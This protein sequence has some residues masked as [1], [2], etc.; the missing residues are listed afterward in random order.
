MEPGV[1]ALEHGKK[2]IQDWHQI[3]KQLINQGITEPEKI[4]E[5]IL[6]RDPETKY[7]VEVRE[8][9]PIF[10]GSAL[11]SIKGILNYILS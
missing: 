6:R 5:E 9:N 1:Q 4:L 3:I 8:N 10:K 2:K 7:I 11:Q